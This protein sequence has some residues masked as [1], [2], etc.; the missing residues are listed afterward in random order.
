MPRKKQKEKAKKI[1]IYFILSICVI[2]IPL[3]FIYGYIY[4]NVP[5]DT[6]WFGAAFPLSTFW[7]MVIQL[8]FLFVVVAL[9]G[10]YLEC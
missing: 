10:K 6:T 1:A 3:T 2:I 5:G 9:L 7:S 8:V 4:T